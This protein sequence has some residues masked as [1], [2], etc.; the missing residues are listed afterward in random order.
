MKNNIFETI[1]FL[2]LVLISSIRTLSTSKYRKLSTEEDHSTKLDLVLLFMGGL[3]MIIPLFYLFTPWLDFADY[4][5]PSWLSWTGAF[6]FIGAAGL[7]WITHQSM[8]RNWTPTLGFRSEHVLI[9]EG[10]FKFIRHPMYAAHLLWALAQP[11]LL[12]NWIAGL[13]FLVV[14]IPLYI[15]RIPYEEKMM[16]DKF[17]V[18]YSEYMKRTGRFFPKL[19]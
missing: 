6:L 18:E 19:F 11:L 14:S 16:L 1:Y 8:G 10:I 4:T 9:T 7:L 3:G 2:E 5:L 12:H 15:L 17:G 13:S